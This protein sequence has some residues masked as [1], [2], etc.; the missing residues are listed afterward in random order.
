MQEITVAAVQ[1]KPALGE[2][3]DNLVKMSDFVS[4]IAS[5]QKVDL[6]LF[7][8]LATSGYE[9]GVK[10]TDVAQIVPGPTVT[11]YE[12]ELAPGVKVA[13]V[14][15]LAHDIAYALATPDVR[16]LA[17]IPGRSAIGVEVPNRRRRA[18]VK[19]RGRVHGP[20]GAAGRRQAAC[21]VCAKMPELALASKRWVWCRIRPR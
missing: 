3:E 14:T 5:Q 16:I 15:S 21:R 12:I 2:I 18:A 8:E 4:K 11:R 13:R 1:M 20:R 10:F 7:P 9:M 17:P 6:I 19:T